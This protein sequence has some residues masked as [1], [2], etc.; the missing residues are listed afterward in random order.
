MNTKVQQLLRE[1]D[2]AFRQPPLGGLTC[3]VAC[4]VNY[5]PGLL[6][7]IRLLNRMSL[8]KQNIDPE[9]RELFVR[10]Q[11]EFNPSKRESSANNS[12]RRRQHGVENDPFLPPPARSV[13]GAV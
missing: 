3:R 12:E 13:T 2:S 5:G 4:G 11:A 10:A 6:L 7:C 8:K 9:L 1:R